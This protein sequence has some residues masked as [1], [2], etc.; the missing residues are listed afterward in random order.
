LHSNN[1]RQLLAEITVPGMAPGKV[2]VLTYELVYY[3]PTD[4]T[5][6]YSISGIVELNLASGA[7]NANVSSKVKVAHLIQQSGEIDEQINIFVRNRNRD[8][9]LKLQRKSVALLEEAAALEDGV[10]IAASLLK[11]A[12]AL[13]STLESQGI[14]EESRQQYSH[15]GYMKRR[16]S[17]SYVDHYA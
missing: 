7:Y 10:G 1:T 9:A 16:G 3:L 15:Q 14:T 13:L 4:L 8:E 6:Q 2:E 12:K 17:F 11:M 5:K